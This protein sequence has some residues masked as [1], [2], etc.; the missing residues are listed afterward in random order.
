[1]RPES[2]P[3]LGALD[4][5][6]LP[7]GERATDMLNDG[8]EAEGSRAGAELGVELGQVDSY[9]VAG[10]GLAEDAANGLPFIW[11]GDGDGD[12]AGAVRRPTVR[13]GAGC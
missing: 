4:T 9:A 13:R 10:D 1:M 11:C 7:V 5:R 8:D 2:G 12:S 3:V 6:G